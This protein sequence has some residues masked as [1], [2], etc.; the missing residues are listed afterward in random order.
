MKIIVNLAGGYGNQL[1]CYA[2]GYAMAREKNASLIL[3]TSMQDNGIARK[4]ELLNLN[5]EYSGRITYPIKRDLFSR[6]IGNRC[7]KKLALGIKTKGYYEKKSSIYEQDA[8]YVNGD[9][10]YYEGNW[11]SYKYFQKYREELVQILVPKTNRGQKVEKLR[12][13]MM[14]LNSIS[15]HVRRGDYVSIGCDIKMDYYDK[16]INLV[17]EKVS[18][19]PIFYVFS[20]D[21]QFCKDYFQKYNN[22]S[23]FRY[24]D[25]QSDNYTID[26]M[27]IMSAAH[28]NIIANSSY[29]WWAAYL[30]KYKDK[31]VICPKKDMWQGDFYPEEWI[32]IDCE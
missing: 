23:T 26:D 31:V 15:I 20:D 13:E 16:A 6:I 7:S 3:D 18:E 12:K 2:F 32:K 19:N 21:I 11:Q 30:N 9:T 1:F 17:L 22:S 28:H 14:D 29:S 24:L 25:Y 10:I 27:Y 4:L 5:I 8:Q